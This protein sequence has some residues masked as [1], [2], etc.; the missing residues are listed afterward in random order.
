LVFTVVGVVLLLGLGVWQM[1]RRAEKRA[2]I[3]ELSSNLSA[4]PVPLPPRVDSPAKW[5]YVRVTLA[6]RFIDGRDMLLSAR[7]RQGRAG[8]EL[9]SV[10]QRD[11]GGPPVLVNRGFVPL[12]W[13]APAARASTGPSKTQTVVGVARLPPGKSFVQPDNDPIRM[14][15]WVWADL[16]AMAAAAGVA[17]FFPLIV[18]L[19]A[20]DDADPSA[21]PQPTPLR[22]DLPDNHLSYALTW[23]ALA[24]ALATIY[25]L[26][27]RKAGKPPLDAVE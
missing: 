13:R 1:E 14:G 7:P 2:L 22:I 12:E 15:A 17:E 16:P 24:A 4:L 26:W 9:M 8:Y 23:W 11:D 6:G 5:T 3:A 25:M 19:Q 10:F 18:E 27:R 21:F 20:A